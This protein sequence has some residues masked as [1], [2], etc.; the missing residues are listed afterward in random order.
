MNDILWTFSRVRCAFSRAFT[1]AARAARLA[2]RGLPSL[3]TLVSSSAVAAESDELLEEAAVPSVS[4]LIPLVPLALVL[5]SH[6]PALATLSFVPGNAFKLRA[7]GLT[8]FS[9][10]KASTS[11]ASRIACR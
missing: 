1:A 5:V 3:H 4:L 10:T 6:V 9:S 8:Q 7:P 11:Y 2:L